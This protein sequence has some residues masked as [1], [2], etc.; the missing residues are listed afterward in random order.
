MAELGLQAVSQFLP[1]RINAAI[2]GV[3]TTIKENGEEIRLRLGYPPSITIGTNEYLTDN[4]I[5]VEEKD[6]LSALELSSRYSVH[7]V[8]DQIRKG[9]IT[10]SGGHRIG[11]CG[12]AITENGEIIGFR[13]LSSVNVRI[14]R[15]VKGLARPFVSSLF[16]DDRFSNTLIISPPGAGKTTFLRDLIRCLSEG[17]AKKRALRIGVADERGEL[18]AMWD[19]HPQ[20]DLGRNTDILFGAGKSESLISLLRG[21]NPQVLAVDEITHPTDVQALFQAAGCGVAL[22][23]TAHGQTHEEMRIRPIYKDMLEKKIFKKALLIKVRDNG[24]R[25]ITVEELS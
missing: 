14:A 13:K 17:T 10:V 6:L 22:I 1:G 21:M 3:P 19:G 7:T 23:A 4:S 20:F 25:S 2:Q 15:D 8:M 16:H 12:E 18:S 11:L 9:F 5:R 24:K